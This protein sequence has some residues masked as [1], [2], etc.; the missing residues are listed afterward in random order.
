MRSLLIHNDNVA[1]ID[2]YSDNIKF[3]AT[4]DTDI[5]IS[6]DILAD[7]KSC[8]P[9]IVFIKDNLSEN[10][11]ELLG[12]RVAYH[13]RL[14]EELK[15]KRYIPIV[16][17]SDI[18]GC[19]LN[20]LTYLGDILFTP[21]VFLLH[22]SSNA[23]HTTKNFEIKTLGMEEYR[24]MFLNRIYLEA[25]ENSSKHSI[26]NEW[27]IY[28]WAKFLKISNSDAVNKNEYRIASTLYFKYLKAKYPIQKQSGIQHVP[29]KPATSGKILYIDDEWEK[30]WKDIFAA[31]FSNVEQIIFQALETIYK[32]MNFDELVEYTD[33]SIDSF[34]PDLIILD[35]RLLDRDHKEKDE[36]NISGIK[37]LQHIKKEINP[38][39]Q[40]IMLTAS[41]KS[42]ILNKANQYGI[43]G[44]IKKEH[45]E[46]TH[47]K[48][49]DNFLKLKDQVDEGLERKYLKEVWI[50]RSN[51][52][53]LVT[54]GDEKFSQIIFETEAVF[55]ILNSDME[56]KY[57]YAML[58]IF[59]CIELLN[60][61][62]IIEK[63]DS[64]EKKTL[65]YWQDSDRRIDNH[66][67]KSTGNKITSI[68]HNKLNYHLLD[69][70]INKIVCCRNY[71]VH[72]NAH[73]CKAILIKK[74]QSENIAT[75]FKML[76]TILSKI[77]KG[78]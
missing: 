72:G 73:G 17:L 63:Y 67:N 12:L 22:N 66:G 14:S 62:Y 50:I 3:M 51:I 53:D 69:K 56:N 29:K 47:I 18:D 33:K 35:M 54:L 25:P 60:D 70:E 59:K 24:D 7:L 6:N 34:D 52:L 5:Y 77:S 49:K 10:Y 42:T 26:A 20:K 64:I 55:E 78:E 48:T 43:L 68:L 21:N 9:D 76:H 15:D 75:W 40:V 37:L 16:V 65:A 46:D 30:G 71:S 61:F 23:F 19:M 39:I 31:Y 28:R 36:K 13:I 2:S 27:S 41:G 8:D 11:L 4:T 32:D 74:P 38:G 45:P 57:I 1:N 58:S 44:Y